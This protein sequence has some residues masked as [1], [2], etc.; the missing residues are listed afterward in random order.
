[1]A[2]IIGVETLQH[3]N[4]TTAATIDSSG[5]ILQPAKPYLYIRGNGTGW[6]SGVGQS[7]TTIDDWD[8]ADS[9]YVSQG[10]MSYSGGIVTVPVDGLYAFNMSFG[11]EL[12][13]AERVYARVIRTRGGTDTELYLSWDHNQ[14]TGGQYEGSMSI[15]QVFKLEAGDK[16]SAEEWTNSSSE[17]LLFQ[18]QYANFS[19]TF[20]G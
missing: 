13:N 6:R 3:T 19:V 10:D 9:L 17:R 15:N 2:S 20:L 5:R 11:V 14:T 18:P 16:V 4:G 1:M 8:T 7:Y 12:D